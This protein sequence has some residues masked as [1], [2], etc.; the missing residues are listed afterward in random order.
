MRLSR[1]KYARSMYFLEEN[2]LASALKL[3]YLDARTLYPD[4]PKYTLEEFAAY[5]YAKEEP[6]DFVVRRENQA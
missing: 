3:G 1:S 4:M 6:G 2:T 5:F